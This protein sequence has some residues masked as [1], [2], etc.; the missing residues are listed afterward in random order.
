[1]LY[2]ISFLSG[3]KLL[4]WNRWKQILCVW[5]WEKVSKLLTQFLLIHEKRLLNIFTIK[6]V[7]IPYK[8]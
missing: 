2:T 8:Y 7:I 3:K 1:M 6:S 5:K 4:K